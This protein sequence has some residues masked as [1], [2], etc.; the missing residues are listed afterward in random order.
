MCIFTDHLYDDYI[1]FCDGL[2]EGS[3]SLDYFRRVLREDFFEDGLVQKVSLRERP[4]T[5]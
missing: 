5:W 3:V 4:D 1:K 2:D